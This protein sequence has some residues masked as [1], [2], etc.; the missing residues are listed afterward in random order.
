MSNE[1]LDQFKAGLDAPPG[2][3]FWAPTLVQNFHVTDEG[4][5]ATMGLVNR[6]HPLAFTVVDRDTFWVPLDI[7]AGSGTE[8]TI[9]A[10]TSEQIIDFLGSNRWKQMLTHELKVVTIVYDAWARH[11]NLSNDSATQDDEGR[12]SSPRG[13]RSGLPFPHNTAVI[14]ALRPLISRLFAKVTDRSPPPH[15]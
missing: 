15:H 13:G 7:L 1:I 14:N 8:Q 12:S 6:T 5:R 9:G 3:T 4:L 11:A 10:S 2:E